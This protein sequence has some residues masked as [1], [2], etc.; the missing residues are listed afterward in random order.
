MYL[1]RAVR[2]VDDAWIGNNIED[3]KYPE[4]VS[5]GL[6]LA[7]PRPTYHYQM[8]RTGQSVTDSLSPKIILVFYHPECK[9]KKKEI[10][11]N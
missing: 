10:E 7:E 1:G 9:R 8:V 3:V 5:A 2:S 11:L 4:I 6:T